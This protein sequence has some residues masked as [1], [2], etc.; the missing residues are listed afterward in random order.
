MET[1]KTIATL[2]LLAAAAAPAQQAFY[3]DPP[4]NTHPWAV[5]DKN[6]PQPVRVEPG[7]NNAPPSDAIVLF[8]GNDLEQNWVSAKKDGGPAKWDV[9]D[10]GIIQCKPGSGDIKTKAKF[11]DCQ[12]HI[13]WS[14]PTQVKG[15]SQGRG[16]SGLF[17]MGRS[18]V[19][20]LDNFDNPTYADG[21][22]AS[23]YGVNPP[24]A[25]ALNRPG[26]FNA[27]DIVFRRPIFVGGKEVDPGYLT[28][29]CNGVLVQDHTPLE[30]GGGH[31]G[32]SKPRPFPEMDSLRL[33]DH[34]NTTRFRNIWYRPLPPRS[35]EG[36]TNGKLTPEA[37]AA[38][39]KE[40]AAEIRDDAKK[41]LAEGK[42]RDATMRLLESLAYEN[43][44]ATRAEATQL[45][46]KGMAELQNVPADRLES[47]KREIIQT[48]DA[49]AYLT[50]HQILP[51][52]FGPKKII[53]KIIAEQGWNKKK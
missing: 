19:Q 45:A 13:E 47:I 3:G 25:N 27:Y 31:K 48:K 36:G 22:A 17:L 23:V 32:R 51:A 2:S 26:E 44:D 53:E 41:M 49:F 39:R 18:E 24:M 34:G 8:S 6:R 21:F 16:N 46:E 29:F 38:K 9:V 11:G 20:V 33:Q 7:K 4:D 1:F 15:N 30:G 52:D 14:A 40:I 35:I 43:D 42:D 12:L 37:T 28:V 10:G 50:K 5:H